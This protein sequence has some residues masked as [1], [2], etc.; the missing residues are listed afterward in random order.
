M[1]LSRIIESASGDRSDPIDCHRGN[2]TKKM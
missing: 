1:G 2:H